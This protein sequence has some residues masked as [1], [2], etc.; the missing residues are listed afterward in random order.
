MGEEKYYGVD[1]EKQ[2]IS[3]ILE[4]KDEEIKN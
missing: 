3:W 1:N 2:N 4:T